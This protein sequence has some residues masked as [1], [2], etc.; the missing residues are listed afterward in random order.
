MADS[1]MSNIGRL[2]YARS[3]F[4]EGVSKKGELRDVNQDDVKEMSRAMMARNAQEMARNAQEKASMQQPI[5]TGG[6]GVTVREPEPPFTPT[7]IADMKKE[8]HD[9]RLFKLSDSSAAPIKKG[10]LTFAERFICDFDPKLNPDREDPR[11]FMKAANKENPMTLTEAA[12]ICAYTMEAKPLGE[13][14]ESSPYTVSNAALRDSTTPLPEQIGEFVKEITSG[15]SKLP[16]NCRPVSRN[17]MHK[18]DEDWAK[19]KDMQYQPKQY[20][21]A[22]PVLAV[23]EL[24]LLSTSR[25]AMGA[26]S[27]TDQKYNWNLLILPSTDSHS[28]GKYISPLSVKG[29]SKNGEEEVLFPPGVKFY[30]KDRREAAA[31]VVFRSDQGEF[32]P[33]FSPKNEQPGEVDDSVGYKPNRHELRTFMVLQE[34]PS[35][36]LTPPPPKPLTPPAPPPNTG[37]PNTY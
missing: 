1:Y 18:K 31:A 15:L 5:T 2:P 7:E 34:L 3:S 21:G 16:S 23:T 24:T 25:V 35:K 9:S 32:T 12:A 26:P 33:D 37:A 6:Q 13:D 30:V 14:D 4:T 29:G 19:A 22:K 10:F 8:F 27:F 36:P 17:E 11:A 28:A 20:D